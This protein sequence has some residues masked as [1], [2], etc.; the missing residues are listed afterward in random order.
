LRISKLVGSQYQFSKVGAAEYLG[1]ACEASLD[2]LIGPSVEPETNFEAVEPIE[3][4]FGWKSP[5]A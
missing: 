1:I 2:V 4:R 5:E 3:V